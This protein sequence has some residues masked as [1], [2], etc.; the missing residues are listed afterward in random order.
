MSAARKR[1]SSEECN[2]YLPR[3]NRHTITPSLL[4]RKDSMRKVANL[5]FAVVY[6]AITDGL[7]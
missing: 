3:K 5:C 7:P 2:L 1:L 6:H 4:C